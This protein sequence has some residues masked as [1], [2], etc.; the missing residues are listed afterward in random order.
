MAKQRISTTT[1]ARQRFHPTLIWRK[2]V[3]RLWR[4]IC[5]P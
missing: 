5:F 1:G 4:M 3:R 2:T